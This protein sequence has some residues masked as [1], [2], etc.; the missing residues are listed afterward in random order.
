MADVL[1]RARS[2]AVR[3]KLT[4]EQYVSRGIIKL[5]SLSSRNE[6]VMI[7]SDAINEGIDVSEAIPLLKRYLPAMDQFT[8][9][10]AVSIIMFHHFNKEEDSEVLSFLRHEDP[11][12]AGTAADYMAVRAFTGFS[13]SLFVPELIR[14][15]YN[16]ND[17]VARSAFNAV[18]AAAILT[19]DE[20]AVMYVRMVY[21]QETGQC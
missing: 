19:G 11:W 12:I 6:G 20:T 5:S 3:D 10:I 4:P 2:A 17:D 13:V 8:Q 9:G 1:E 21:S 18:S 15:I 14:M 16:K 7:I